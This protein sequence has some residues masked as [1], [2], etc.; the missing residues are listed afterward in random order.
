MLGNGIEWNGMKEWMDE[1]RKEGRDGPMREKFVLPSSSSSSWDQRDVRDAL[2]IL[3]F[4]PPS[5]FP[6]LLL[7]PACQSACLPFYAPLICIYY[8]QPHT[9]THTHIPV[10]QP[11]L[12]HL[13]PIN[14]DTRRERDYP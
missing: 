1:G 9:R 12:V 3:P 14:M 13:I 11:R 5:L 10:L 8:T 2:D 6:S 4:F 7:L